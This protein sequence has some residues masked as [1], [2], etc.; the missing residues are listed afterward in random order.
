MA[1]I[2]SLLGTPYLWG[3]RTP[4]GYDCSAFVQQVLLE[5]GIALPRDAHEQSLACRPLR[6]GEQEAFGDLAF[7]SV[8][9]KGRMGHVG[10]ALGGGWF[11]HARGVVRVDSMEAS[12]RLHPKD[13]A[14]Q[15]RGWYRPLPGR[16]AAARKN[17]REPESA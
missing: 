3:G 17:Q 1:R 10:L 8:R 6:E 7:F 2:R 12:N 16:G 5:Q 13:L 11:A 9:R 4:A 14:A 15:F